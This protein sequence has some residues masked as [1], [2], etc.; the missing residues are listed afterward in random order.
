MDNKLLA[1][2]EWVGPCLVWTGERDKDGYGRIRIDGR[3]I[4]AHRV[5]YETWVGP[6][7]K[8]GVILHTCDNPPCINPEHLRV[9]TQKENVR[10]MLQ[11]GR[12]PHFRNL[13]DSY[14]ASR[15]AWWEQM[16]RET[17]LYPTEMAEYRTKNPPP[18]F[19][20][21]LTSQS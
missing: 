15:Q 9:G 21:W 1:K 6:I 12:S 4:A 8:G 20:M 19:K 5:A 7:F 11:K 14:Y 13:M 17:A 2:S 10:D 18:T 3:R 16:E